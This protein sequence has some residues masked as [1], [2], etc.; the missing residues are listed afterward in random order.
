MTLGGMVDSD[1][2]LPSFVEARGLGSFQRTSMTIKMETP[3]TYFYTDRPRTVE[4]HIGMPKGLMT[5]WYPFVKD[6]GP[7]PAAASYRPEHS[8]I[9]WKKVDLLP[10][11]SGEKLV[12]PVAGD[13][14]WRFARETDAALVKVVGL[15]SDGKSSKVERK[16]QYEKFLF[17]RGLGGFDLPLSVRTS[18]GPKGSMTLTL[19]DESTLPVTGIFAVRVDRGAISFGTTEN[20]AGRESRQVAL[21][22]LL[23]KPLPLDE[24]VPLVKQALAHRLVEAG[25]YEK[26]ATAMVNTWERSYFRTD[27][28]RVLYVLPRT[29]VDSIIPIQITPAP[30]QLE[31]VM[32]GRVEVLT[33]DRER[34]I[35]SFVSQLGDRKFTTREAAT[36][37]LARLGRIGE[38]ALRRVANTTKD[39]EVRARALDLIQRFGSH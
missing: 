31:R 27:G 26:E 8:Y 36:E 13:L 12:N 38:P 21:S 33:P 10:I 2:V 15:I 9:H 24:G 23:S 35:E 5:H 28:L 6:Y 22:S 17:Y 16:D 11:Q 34:Q 32:V 14:N 7:N 37:G 18:E 1:E 19:T 29:M 4:V 20:L 30:D 25:L 39:P 3:V